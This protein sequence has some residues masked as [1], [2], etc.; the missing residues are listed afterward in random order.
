MYDLSK[1]KAVPKEYG[2]NN[3]RH[4]IRLTITKDKMTLSAEAVAALGDPEYVWLGIDMENRMV[5]ARPTNE[6]DKDGTKLSRKDLKVR[7]STI[8]HYAF[9]RT[10][11][12]SIRKYDPAV[13]NI[14]LTGKPIDE[15]KN[16]L[17][18]DY[19]MNVKAEP[20]R[21]ITRNGNQ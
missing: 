3:G 18:F 16:G 10:L 21:K 14:I 9:R 8:S 19:N 12:K 6:Q 7:S 20:R 13:V 2:H 5:L 15:V 11:L 1:F 17:V 4:D